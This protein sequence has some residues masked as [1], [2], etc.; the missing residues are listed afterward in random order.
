MFGYV[1]KAQREILERMA[2]D[3]G[4]QRGMWLA[5]RTVCPVDGCDELECETGSIGNYCG[6]HDTW[7]VR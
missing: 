5:T 1:S 2:F 4:V 7:V 3:Q 6:F